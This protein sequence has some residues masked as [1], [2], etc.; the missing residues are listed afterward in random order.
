MSIIYILIN[1]IKQYIVAKIIYLFSSQSV[2]FLIISTSIAVGIKGIIDFFQSEEK[3]RV[4]FSFALI[5]GIISIFI[6]IMGTLVYDEIV[7]VNKF[8]LNLNVKRGIHE[9]A[10]SE[11]ESAIDDLEDE[12]KKDINPEMIDMIDDNSNY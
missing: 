4:E 1:F 2:S 12:D 6:I 11:V 10:L 3:N 8:G 9:R 7:I 5:F